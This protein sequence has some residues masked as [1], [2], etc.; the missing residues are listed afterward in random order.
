MGDFPVWER[1]K[2]VS[3]LLLSEGQKAFQSGFPEGFTLSNK[4]MSHIQPASF[5][6]SSTAPK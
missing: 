6:A 5:K 1:V 2:S 3:L 4:S